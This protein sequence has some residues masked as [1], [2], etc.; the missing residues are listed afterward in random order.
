[1]A[2]YGELVGVA[3]QLA[4]D[5]IDIV[6]DGASSG[7]T[8]GT[9]L[10][11]G[12]PTLPT[13]LLDRAADAG[14]E[15]AREVRALI[16]TDLSTDEA[17]GAAVSALAAHP[18]TEQAWRIAYEWADR[19]IAALAPCLKAPRKLPSPHSPTP[20]CTVKGNYRVKLTTLKR[21]MQAQAH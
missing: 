16:D 21:G 14:D 3:F 5:V 9:D 18:V 10:R 1:M 8:R 2:R 12:V 6:S 13:I 4:D 17:L 7:K 11:E 20:W 15:S 19:A